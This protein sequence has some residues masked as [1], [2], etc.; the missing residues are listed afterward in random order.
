LLHNS[1]GEPLISNGTLT[2]STFFT[3]SYVATDI[4]PEAPVKN[5]TNYLIHGAARGDVS[6]FIQVDVYGGGVSNYN[7]STSSFRNRDAFLVF[8]A[9]GS[10][11]GT[12]FPTDGIDIVD[13]MIWSLDPNPTRA[14]KHLIYLYP[15][16]RL[17][18]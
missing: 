9:S 5:W 12:A 4:I 2:R 14:C 13:N 8:Q 17:I 15:E 7:T 6:W 18:S 16:L 11:N 10:V 1:Y 3:K